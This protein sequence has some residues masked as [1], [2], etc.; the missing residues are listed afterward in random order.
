[1]RGV[2][3][4]RG[5]GTDMNNAPYEKYR[6]ENLILRDELAIDRT[7]LA[8]ERTLL[9]YL[10][11]SLALLIA[12]VSIVH[13]SQGGWFSA[14]GFACIP[15]GVVIGI[16]GAARYWKMHRSISLVRRHAKTK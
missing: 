9:S 13:F 2:G 5:M 16:V 14:V 6:G 10:R 3:I 15:A 11:S 1:M 8:N 12:G 7:N 4:A